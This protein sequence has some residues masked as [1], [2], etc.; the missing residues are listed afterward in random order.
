VTAARAEKPVLASILEDTEPRSL[1]DGALVLR[2]IGRSAMT[3]EGLSRSRAR[4]EELLSR[5]LGGAVRVGTESA[6]DA[7]AR[8][9]APERVT[10]D[11]ARAERTRALRA[12]HPALDQA[13]DALDLELLE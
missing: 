6:A 8:A 7:P 11:G 13:V 3:A 9:A 10:A 5:L 4:L 1:G 2:V 12:K